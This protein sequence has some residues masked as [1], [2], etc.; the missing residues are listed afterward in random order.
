MP[1]LND[2]VTERDGTKTRCELHGGCTEDSLFD[3]DHFNCDA[4]FGDGDMT[5]MDL[6]DA[7]STPQMK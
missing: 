7:A 3:W 5:S 4:F 6:L 2:A 1:F